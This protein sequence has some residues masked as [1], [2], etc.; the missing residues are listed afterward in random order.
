MKKIKNTDVL[1]IGAGPAGCVAAAYLKKQGFD[2]L[3][4]EKQ[5]FPRFVIGESLLP[6]CMEHL[7]EAELLEA[8]KKANFKQKMGADF[9]YQGKTCHFSFS[10]QFTK[11]WSW[12][13]QVTRADF[14]QVLAKEIQQKGVEVYFE[15]SVEDVTFETN[16][17]LTKIKNKANEIFEIKSKFVID[18]SGY[19]RVLPKLLDLNKASTLACR[20]AV[21]SHI[22]NKYKSTEEKITKQIYINTIATDK[23][24]MWIIPFSNGNTSIGIVGEEEKIK[25]LAKNK[26]EK[27][28]TTLATDPLTQQLLQE[29]DLVFEPK[30]ISGYSVGVKQMY[31][32]GFVLCG[33]STE[34]L[35]P[36]F[37][38]GVTLATESGL[39]AAKL[40]AKQLQGEKVN[41]QKD[42][43]DY[44]AEGI[45][46]FRSYID[47][48]YN[49]ALHTIFFTKQIRQDIKNQICSVLAGYVWDKNNP[50]V[51]KH[52]KVLKSLAKVIQMYPNHKH[53]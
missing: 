39:L 20:A 10:E 46:V 51:S 53:L 24:W 41:W 40:T 45:A 47:A 2:V 15:H 23:T 52:Q 17:Q 19:G 43:A 42:Y 16:E 3:V 38:S 21:F 8:V 32:N 28:K 30:C 14:D 37:S 12:T 31:G 9:Y 5:K 1:I 18:A 26:G 4:V 7:E 36:V 35:D 48:W 33:N 49:G 44:L 27:F 11:G 29:I 50:F 13:W 6:R 34:F 25:I 22:K